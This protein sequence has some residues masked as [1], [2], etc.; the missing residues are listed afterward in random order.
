MEELELLTMIPAPQPYA[1]E[2]E[3]EEES[4][5]DDA[6]EDEDSDE[7]KITL[8]NSIMKIEKSESEEEHEEMAEM[9][10]LAPEDT[11]RYG[12]VESDEDEGIE[13]GSVENDDSKED[14]DDERTSLVPLTSQDD[15]DSN[16]IIE[17]VEGSSESEDEE[18]FSDGVKEVEENPGTKRQGSSIDQLQLEMAK[19][20]RIKGP[21]KKRRE[22]LVKKKNKT[23][24]DSFNIKTNQKQ[25]E[26]KTGKIE[27][28]RLG[29]KGRKRMK[30]T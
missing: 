8:Q 29:I 21:E 30:V 3:S 20:K 6:E 18:A 16:F 9:V 23:R 7:V 1:E 27:T 15:L 17:K 12:E 11:E 10:P 24:S 22:V 13:E 25:K 14:S 28:T 19:N 2:R 5:D 26:K 4:D